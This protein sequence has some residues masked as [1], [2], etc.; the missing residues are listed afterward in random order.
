MRQ[1]VKN[2]LS[3][4]E[5]DMRVVLGEVALTGK[6]NEIE[7][8][9][10]IVRR[11]HQFGEEA[12]GKVYYDSSSGP[13]LMVSEPAAGWPAPTAASGR[14]PAKKPR[15]QAPKKGEYPKFAWEDNGRTLLK[16]GW[17]KKKRQEYR[18]RAPKNVLDLLREKLEKLGANSKTFTM[19]NILPLT[20][21]A[22]GKDT[23]SY[24]VYLAVAYLEHEGQLERTRDKLSLTGK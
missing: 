23:P 15:P 20:D 5:A 9:A 21:P 19:E 2:I 7:W 12:D 24:Q 13:G 1:R 8:L 17:S 10:A 18:H 6:V 4:A 22:S 11:L 3:S 16:I 14:K